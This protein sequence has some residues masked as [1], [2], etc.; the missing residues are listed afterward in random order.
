MREA[1]ARLSDALILAALF[2][3]N[4]LLGLGSLSF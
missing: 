4:T 3:G 2:A 1:A